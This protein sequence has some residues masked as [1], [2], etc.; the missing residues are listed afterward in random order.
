MNCSIEVKVFVSSG[1]CNNTARI[2]ESRTQ[3]NH[4]A[5]MPASA[6]MTRSVY[7]LPRYVP[8]SA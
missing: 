5:L 1:Y 2:V 6:E 3:M 4:R 7:Y 8:T